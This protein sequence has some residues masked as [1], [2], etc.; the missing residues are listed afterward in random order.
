MCAYLGDNRQKHDFEE[1]VTYFRQGAVALLMG[2]QCCRRLGAHE[3]IVN[4]AFRNY[5]FTPVSA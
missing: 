3:P 5:R 2:S 4:P 1:N